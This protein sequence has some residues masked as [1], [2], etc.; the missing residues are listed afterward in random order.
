MGAA[1]IALGILVSSLTENQII[2]A[3]V[4]FGILLL[5]FLIGWA[6]TFVGSSFG[7]VLEHL[8]IMKHFQN[9]TKGVIDTQ[10]I[11]FYINFIIFSLFL[12]G[13]SLESKKWRG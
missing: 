4:T 5:F 10:D 8:S 3:A 1:F 9:F 6:S 7:S 13:M 2:A 11:I 12:T